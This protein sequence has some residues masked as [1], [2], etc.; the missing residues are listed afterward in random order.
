[1]KIHAKPIVALVSGAIGLPGL[2]CQTVKLN[3]CLLNESGTSILADA[4]H[5]ATGPEALII[6]WSVVEN[7]S[8][9]YTYSYTVNNPAGDVL[10]PGSYAP[11]TPEIVD[12]FSL[13]FNAALPNAVVSGPIGG[14]SA[15]NF[16]AFGLYWVLYPDVVK[17]GT[18][19]GQ[20][21][22]QSELPPSP[23]NASASDD[24]PPSP[25]ASPN[26]SPVPVPGTGNFSVPEPA[27]TTLLALTALLLLPFGSTIRKFN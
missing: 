21:S 27:T 20:L 16:G 15:F 18:S 3:P 7:A 2:L 19:S 25:W 10:L 24:S 5:T 14:N 26:G 13:D 4:F 22:F 12:S 17:A 23:G 11:G 9:V 8:D 1:M 6:S